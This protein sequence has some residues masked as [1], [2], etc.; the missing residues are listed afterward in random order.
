[1]KLAVR[2]IK[3]QTPFVV[4]RGAPVRNPTPRGVSVAPRGKGT[5]VDFGGELH[6][7]V[8][9]LAHNDDVLRHFS[10]DDAAAGS[11]A[12]LLGDIM[13]ARCRRR[14]PQ[15]VAVRNLMLCCPRSLRRR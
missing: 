1:M 6:S 11:H 4:G 13:Q 15:V 14:R 8:E 7:V 10:V 2:A 3:P 9:S 5:A 12:K